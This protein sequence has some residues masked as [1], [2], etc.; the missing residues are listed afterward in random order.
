M[1]IQDGVAA[2]AA[3]DLQQAASAALAGVSP[4]DYSSYEAA[5][6]CSSPSMAA[7]VLVA[8]LI[9]L[10][11]GQRCGSSSSAHNGGRRSPGLARA[12]SGGFA[13][14]GSPDR[15]AAV[16]D[17]GSPGVR[18]A[19]RPSSAP[20]KG[21]SPGRSPSPVVSGSFVRLMN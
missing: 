5:G 3:A 9:A 15:G 10:K 20:C 12:G 4:E 17:G 14:A 21:K 11:A 6:N 19:Q 8:G 13:A 18:R 1:L 16:G 7:A 2:I